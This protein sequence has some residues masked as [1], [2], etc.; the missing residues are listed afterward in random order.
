MLEECLI[1][2]YDQ[3]NKLQIVLKLIFLVILNY[4]FGQWLSYL[5][6][7]NFLIK[8]NETHYSLMYSLYDNKLVVQFLRGLTSCKIAS[9]IEELLQGTACPV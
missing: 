2:L 3:E 6:P 5:Y 8:R 1:V 7:Q 4:K 9:V